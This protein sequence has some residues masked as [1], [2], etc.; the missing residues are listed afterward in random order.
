MRN[1]RS[2]TR[3]ARWVIAAG[4]TACAAV[5]TVLLVVSSNS[6]ASAPRALTADEANRLAIT[7]FRN[8][9]SGGRAVRITVPDTA[10]GLTVTASVDFRAKR[11]YGVLRGDGRNSSSDGPIRW[12][13]TELSAAS[14][15]VGWTNRPLQT[16][17]SA[18]D[19]ALRIALGLGAD[20]PDNAQLLPQNGAS[21][22]GQ[23]TVNGH[24]TDVM[25]GPGARDRP[26]TEGTV[27]YWIG[28]DGTM[29]RVQ[30][31]VASEP[32]PVVIDF[33]TQPY[34]APK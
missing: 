24:Q 32:Q 34:V 11:A 3:R 33:D 28:A 23:E 29:Y 8:Y 4:V 21:R 10:G 7:R 6:D 27:R 15:T 26:D 22:I 13:S 17:G 20:R 31:A 25:V 30:V 19:T 18:L 9:A 16:A 2:L 12:T 5:A 14:A 1:L